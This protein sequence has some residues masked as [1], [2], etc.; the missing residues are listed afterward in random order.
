MNIL[1][2]DRQMAPPAANLH[3]SVLSATKT[4]GNSNKILSQHITK[5]ILQ[6]HR[7]YSATCRW[8]SLRERTSH[9]LPDPSAEHWSRQPTIHHCYIS[10]YTAG[11]ENVVIIR[12]IIFILGRGQVPR[13]LL[14]MVFNA[15]LALTDPQRYSAIIL[16][17]AGTGDIHA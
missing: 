8:E 5:H 6:F 11:T 12:I 3:S 4:W 10:K 13:P 14:P 16:E 9:W 15:K 2:C 7:K 1:A 17:T